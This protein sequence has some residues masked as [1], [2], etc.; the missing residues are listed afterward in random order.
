VTFRG[1]V[2]NGV[3]VPEDCTANLPEGTLVEITLVQERVGTG[4]AIIGALDEAPCVP[5]EDVDES[6]RAIKAD[7]RRLRVDPFSEPGVEPPSKERQEA[8][9]SLSGMWKVENPPSDE[10]VERIIEEYRMKKYG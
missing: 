2:T 7:E 1:R 3:I 6:E 5:S 4:S 8:L 9:R 10:E